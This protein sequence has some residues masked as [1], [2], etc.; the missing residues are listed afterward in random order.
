VPRHASS[1][2]LALHARSGVQPGHDFGPA[3]LA[4]ALVALSAGCPT[5]PDGE[6]PTPFVVPPWSDDTPDL[7]DVDVRGARPYRMIAHLHSPHSHD[8][9]DGEPQPGGVLDESCL[10]ELKAGLCATRIDVAFLSD[11]RSHADEAE[12][13]EDLLV[14]RGDDIPVYDDAGNAIANSVDCAMADG[15]RVLLIPGIEANPLMPL[16]TTQRTPELYADGTPDNVAQLKEAGALA[17]IAHAETH[18]PA[19]FLDVPIDGLELYQLHANLAPDLRELLG[20]DPFGFLGDLGPFLTERDGRASPEPDLAV[21]G[22]ATVNDP[23]AVFLETVGAVRPIGVTGGSDSH[24]NVLP[25]PAWDFERIDSYRRSFRWMLNHL[26]IDGELT[27]E[28]A[29]QALRGGRNVV[30]FESIG[31]PLG[32]DF[33][34]TGT[35]LEMGGEGPADGA[36]LHVVPPTL[37]PRS[38]RDETPPDVRTVLYRAH[39]G[40]R[41]VVAET[42]GADPIDVAAPGPGVYRVEVWITPRHLGPY[43]GDWVDEY[44]TVEAPWVQTGGIF[45]R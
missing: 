33:R 30:V 22:F 19:D 36:V 38:P 27:P 31:T 15:R 16:G 9:C 18:D 40:V 20:L 23:A 25:S 10:A 24:R 6:E 14:L 43:L 12:S 21:L 26:W 3:V 13:F 1:S 4:L 41:T 29:K 8:A 2:R 28:S 35:A 42:M 45:L 39:E 7:S 34:A 11:H 32:F 37:D 5:D 44:T 17:W